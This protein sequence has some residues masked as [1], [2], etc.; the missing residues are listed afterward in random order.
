MM[1]HV[2]LG[3]GFVNHYGPRAH[4][5]DPARQAPKMMSSVLL[6]LGHTFMNHYG[7]CVWYR[8]SETGPK[9]F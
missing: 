8:P 9:K 5:M 2:M 3:H 4:G 6:M 1:G 7:H